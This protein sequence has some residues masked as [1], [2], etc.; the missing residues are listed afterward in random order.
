L[1]HQDHSSVELAV[2]VCCSVPNVQPTLLVVILLDSF[3]D[4]VI[5]QV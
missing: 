3:P 4:L 1:C 5:Y 2:S